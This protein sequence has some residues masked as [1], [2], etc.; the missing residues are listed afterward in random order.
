MAEREGQQFGNY[1]LTRLL[2][3]GAFA[4]VY[5][6]VQVYLGTEAAI[7]VLHTQLANAA[8]IE[9]FRLEA[10]TIA[11]LVHPH[12]VRLLDFGVQ[13]STPYL[14]MDYAPNGSLRQFFPPETPLA[15]TV[16][17]PYLKQVA[18][19]LQYAHDQKLI[20]RD[21]KPENMLLGRSKEVLLSDF[22]IAMVAQ[23]SSHQQTQGIAGTAAYMAPEQLQGKPRPASDQY[24][25][26][27]VVY[28]WLS[29]SRP[30]Q[31]T[32]TEVAG[33]HMLA[34][35]PPLRQK[36]PNLSADVERVVLTALA[37]DPK[38]RFASVRAF[39]NAFEQAIQGSTAQSYTTHAQAMSNL[40]GPAAPGSQAQPSLYNAE[41]VISAPPN[42][43]GTALFNAETVISAPPNI[44]PPTPAQPI[45][46]T[47]APPSGPSAYPPA[48]NAGWA[49]ATPSAPPPY[50][51]TFL[52]SLPPAPASPTT[53]LPGQTPPKQGISR[54]AVV[55]GGVAG[56][57]L[58]GSGAAAFALTQNSGSP[59][60]GRNP[61]PT[62]TATATASPT[63]SP[64]ATP[65]ESP[66][67]T[68]TTAPPQPGATLYT[69]RGH[70]Q[71]VD[72]LAWSPNGSRIVSGSFDHTA[73][74]W[75]ALTG[76]TIVT[77]TGHSD[78][79]WTVAWSPNGQYIASGGRDKSVQ[80]W[81]PGS[82]STRTSYTG[83][84]DAIAGVAWSPDSILIASASYDNTV[85][86][87]EALTQQ[88]HATFSDHTDHV[89][90]VD[91]KPDGSLV[92]S[93]SKDK[94]VRV[95]NP[96]TGSGVYVYMGHSA[97][98]AAVAWSPNGARIASGSYDHT[99]Q[100][101][102]ATTGANVV[103]YTGHT[104]NVTGLAWSPDGSRI[105]SSSRDGT[106][107]VWDA[108]TATNILTYRKHASGVDD[109]GWASTGQQ[110]ASA[111]ADRTVQVWLAP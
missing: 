52:T 21:I 28:E 56:L 73:R 88:F 72:T 107:Q 29:G 80:I 96:A 8:E 24:S 95:W 58:I 82:G 2:G 38:D 13:D 77:Y 14:L 92:A 78:Q 93:G 10:R 33:Q 20:H 25:L 68:A 105:A 39:A 110:I 48:F 46:P 17:L 53:P 106:V 111:S 55:I 5:L 64:T 7:K 61:G 16:I 103:T 84:S 108:R 69:Y 32:F 75:N 18:D 50:A 23:T 19:A 57:A 97:G 86:V 41:T 89:W 30:F 59:G 11:T 1:R 45:P 44:P 99:V 101:W 71:E 47:A 51:D 40:P 4:E 85:R 43:P 37:K 100:V 98:V 70:T 27:I 104:D 34:A 22:G 67:A 36:L 66:T 12:I 62:S 102:D 81:N 90:A 3:K 31:G 54:R 60:P 94:T 26:G 6:A 9:K 35:P 79:V 91:W 76:Q 65:T 109:V 87:W 49:A 42:A 74:V 63:A 15:P 83:H